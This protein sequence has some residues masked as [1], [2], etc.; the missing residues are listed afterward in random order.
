MLTLSN[1]EEARQK[2]LRPSGGK[3]NQI[4]D[5]SGTS[6]I[7]TEGSAKSS[8]LSTEM[9]RLDLQL[10]LQLLIERWPTLS[11]AVQQ[12]IMLLVS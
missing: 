10:Q 3:E 8:T 6:H 4:D 11:K 1:E 9:H 5:L 2:L 12:Q 7:C